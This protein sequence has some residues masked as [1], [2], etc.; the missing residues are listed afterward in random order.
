MHLNMAQEMLT[1]PELSAQT[2]DLLRANWGAFC[3]GQIAADYQQLCDTLRR[4][5]HFYK[6]PPEPGD[7]GAFE[8]MLAQNKQMTDWNELKP[9]EAVFIAGYGSHLYYDLDWFHHI[10]IAFV[11]GDWGDRKSRFVD[12]NTLLAHEDQQSLPV[13]GPDTGAAIL[14]VDAAGWLPFDPDYNLKAWQ[15]LVGRQLLPGAEIE[16]LNI[17]A[18]RMDISA[19][20]LARRVSAPEWM[21]ENIFAHVPRELVDQVFE[22]SL[23]AG[24]ALIEDY[25]D[26]ILKTL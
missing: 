6:T 12:H 10:V 25:L 17:F 15:E 1:R 13:I 16:T 23:V 20:E 24:I 7:Y 2:A 9:A 3:L 8:R 21:Q 22:N 19:A 18:G 14:A 5:T 11:V 4:T 26:P